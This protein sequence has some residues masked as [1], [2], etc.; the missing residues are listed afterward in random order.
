MDL[1]KRYIERYGVP[2]S[3]YTDRASHFK[4]NKNEKREEVFSPYDKSKTQIERALKECGI[5]HIHAHSPQGKGR[6]ERL[7]RTLQDRQVL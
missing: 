1:L 2:I 4:V 6:V 3:L 5:C 7:N